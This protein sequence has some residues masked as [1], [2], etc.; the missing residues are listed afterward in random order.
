MLVDAD[1]DGGK[2]PGAPSVISACE[3]SET[4]RC[5]A[6]NIE[7]TGAGGDRGRRQVRL[8]PGLEL[9]LLVELL[10]GRDRCDE[11]I[12]VRGNRGELGRLRGQ[13]RRHYEHPFGEA[14]SALQAIGTLLDV[15]DHIDDVTKVDDL[16]RCQITVGA[17]GPGPTLGNARHEA[18]GGGHHLR[19]RIRNRERRLQGG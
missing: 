9:R 15:F 10:E 17:V 18:R 3:E 1:L 16:R 6:E 14:P 2:G 19:V 8:D 12:A 13:T 11:A 4:I 7:D 5:I